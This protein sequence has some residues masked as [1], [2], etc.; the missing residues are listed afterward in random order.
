MDSQKNE[1]ARYFAAANGFTGFRSYFG[2]VFNP[3]NYDALY[4]IKGGPGTGKSSLMRRI[5]DAISKRGAETEEI[6]CSSDSDSLDGIILKSNDKKIAMLD[7][8][9]P[10]ERD[11]I[12]PGAIDCIINLG[13]CWDANWLK[14]QRDKILTLTSEKKR[15][16]SS[17]YFYLNLAGV[18][19]DRRTQIKKS[20]INI[21]FLNSL[22]K[23]KAELI[24]GATSGEKITRLISGFG[25]KGYITLDTPERITSERYTLCGDDVCAV[26][27][28][29]L[30]SEYLYR[31]GVEF[32][33][34]VNPLDGEATEAVYIPS[35]S[36]FV[37][38]R[39][40]GTEIELYDAM[41]SLTESEKESLRIGEEIYN[42]AIFEGERWFRIAADLH[43]RLE[44]IYTSAMNF[45]LVDNIFNKTLKEISVLLFD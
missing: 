32:I 45:D 8:T 39:E 19:W 10:H 28:L 1:I 36:I 16:Y 44:E 35:L 11:A 41:T 6:L 20:K 22:A 15:A 42:R 34:C 14:A 38:C 17:A 9:S 24:K 25:K 43:A 33:H 30:L 21:R 4:V 29:N 37:S 18:Y 31:Y 5:S 26:E 12:I 27:Y 2:E 13:E 40:G 3:K 7:G 23:S